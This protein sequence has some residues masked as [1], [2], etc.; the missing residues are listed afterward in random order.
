MFTYLSNSLIVWGSP[1]LPWY[2][3]GSITNR[4]ASSMIIIKPTERVKTQLLGSENRKQK[5]W[6]TVGVRYV[7]LL[8]LCG[9]SWYSSAISL[10]CVYSLLTFNSQ[11]EA[12]PD[13]HSQGLMGDAAC[14]LFPWVPERGREVE[15]SRQR[16]GLQVV[17]V[18]W[19]QNVLEHLG[20]RSAHPLAWHCR[21]LLVPNY[22]HIQRVVTLCLTNNL[23]LPALLQR[24]NG[25]NVEGDTG[26]LWG[27]KRITW[28]WHF[29]GD[30]SR[31][32][33]W[34]WL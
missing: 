29:Q 17:S 24:E 4:M 25:S 13:R 21:V 32:L 1:H 27:E 12:L 9:S 3:K 34:V 10:T 22:L 19:Q 2:R 26:S 8:P 11:D 20:E 31:F 7:P 28:N 33:L 30:F 5:A 23:L 16:V 14:K 15:E 6:I 18:A